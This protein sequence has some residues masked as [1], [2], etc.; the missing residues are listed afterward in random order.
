M[1]LYD[2]LG[3]EKGLAVIVAD[4]YSRLSL[5][6]F[7]AVWFDAVD[8]TSLQ[9]HLRGYF[10]V[11]FGGPEAYRGRSLRHAHSGLGITGT[12]FDAVLAHLAA[13]LADSGSAPATIKEVD[14]RLQSL[15]AVLV[16][17]PDL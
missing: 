4:F 12:A 15:R 14:A 3:G 10:A 9:F 1:S 13:T 16:E 2:Q 11:A 8:G 5:D 7:L 6:R 17:I